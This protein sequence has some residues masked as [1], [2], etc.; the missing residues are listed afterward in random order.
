VARRLLARA[1]QLGDEASPEEGEGFS[2]LTNQ[3]GIRL[4]TRVWQPTGPARALVVFCHGYGTSSTSNVA[5]QRVADMLTACGFVCAAID[6]AG[7]GHSAGWRSYVD[8]VESIVD[9]VLQFIDERL[10][11]AF[12]RL[13]IFLRASCACELGCPALPDICGVVPSDLAQVASLS[14]ASSH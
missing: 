14:A 13:P 10:R 6:Y 7:H 5:W 11:M 12:A 1:L 3:R 9:D 2:V 4:Q 8:S